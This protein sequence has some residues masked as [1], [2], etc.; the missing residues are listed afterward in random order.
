MKRTRY[1]IILSRN[2]DVEYSDGITEGM[3]ETEKL[4]IIGKCVR[5]AV[6]AHGSP[7]GMIQVIGM[8]EEEID[9]G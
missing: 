1:V 3:E 9:A 8:G 4:S 5:D 2:G 7:A 6:D